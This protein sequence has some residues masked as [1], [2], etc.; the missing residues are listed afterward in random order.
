M[1]SSVRYRGRRF[2]P[3]AAL[4]PNDCIGDHNNT[5]HREALQDKLTRL[6]PL[7]DFLTTG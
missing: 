2:D 4:S 1:L 7:C 6:G 5:S 3:L